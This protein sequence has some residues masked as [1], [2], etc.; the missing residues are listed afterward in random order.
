MWMGT[1]NLAGHVAQDV[2]NFRVTPQKSERLLQTSRVFLR[3]GAG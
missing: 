3:K 2:T 1:V